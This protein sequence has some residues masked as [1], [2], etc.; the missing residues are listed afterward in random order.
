MGF[1]SKKSMLVSLLA[2]SLA[3]CATPIS[4]TPIPATNPPIT[5]PCDGPAGAHPVAKT[6]TFQLNA[7]STCELQDVYF[8]PDNHGNDKLFKEHTRTKKGAPVVFDYTGTSPPLGDGAYFYY[9]TT[10]PNSPNP[11]GSGGGYIH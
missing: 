8:I 5:L 4:K 6:I 1:L 10:A 2:L 11:D 3:A 9:I 7:G